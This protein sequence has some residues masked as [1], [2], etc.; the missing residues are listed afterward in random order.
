MILAG[1]LTDRMNRPLLLAAIYFLRSL[2]FIVL[3]WAARDISLLFLFAVL[4][5][6][7]DYSTV[8]VTASLA[9][10]HIGLRV[11]GLTMGLL[12]GGH[13]L[14]AAAGAFLA[15]LLFDAYGQYFW[16]WIAAFALAMLAGMLSLA[17]SENSPSVAS[18]LTT[19][20]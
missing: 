12:A 5:G 15:G 1:W 13:A 18:E 14:G 20:G 16:V 7:F 10:S 2:T 19:G 6:L 11:M 17:I 9:A 4:F 8:P 3:I